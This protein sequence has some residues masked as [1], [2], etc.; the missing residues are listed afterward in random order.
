MDRIGLNRF[1]VSASLDLLLVSDVDPTQASP[2]F[3]LCPKFM[4]P[5]RTAWPSFPY[6]P[7]VI[8]MQ[9]DIFEAAT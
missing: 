1:V 4:S 3:S 2:L 7:Y 6:S 8:P 5:T 9:G